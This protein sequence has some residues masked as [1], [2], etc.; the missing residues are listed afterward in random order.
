M[1]QIEFNNPEHGEAIAIA[2]GAAYDQRTCSVV[3]RVRDGKLIGGVIYAN[4][5]GESCAMHSAAWDPH[6]LNRDMLYVIFDYPFNQL[7]VKRIFGCVPEDNVR[8]RDFNRKFGC[9]DVAR[10]EGMFRGNV[11]GIVT[12]LERDACRLLGVRPRSIMSGNRH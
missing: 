8:V 1:D 5:T 11:A 9:K 12:S 7:G 3:A 4:F 10:L 6:W 2:A